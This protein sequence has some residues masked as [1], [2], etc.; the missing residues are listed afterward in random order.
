MSLTVDFWTFG[1]RENTTTIPSS[2]PVKTYSTVLL[3]DNCSV[4]NPALEIREAVTTRVMDW[5]Y[6]YIHEFRRYY[7]V[8]DWVWNLG[9]WVCELQVDVL[10]SFR[11]EIGNQNLYILRSYQ[12][13]SGNTL[14]DG[15]VVD[16]TYPCLASRATYTAYS[17]NNPFSGL[18]GNNDGTYIVGLINKSASGVKYYAFNFLGF[19]V[20]CSQLFN[21]SSG[22]LN[23]DP[24]EISEDLQKALVNPFQYLVSA[25]YIPIPVTW[26]T[27]NNIGTVTTTVEFGWWSV[28]VAQGG[29]ILDPGTLYQ[30]TTS[31]SIP[32]HPSYQSRGN[33]LNL[34][35]YSIYTLR[36]YPF[37]TFD[38]DSESISDWNTLDLYTDVDVCTGKALLT[39]AVNGK[40]NPIRTVESNISVPIPTASVNVDYMNLG[41]KSSLVMMGASAVGQLTSGEGTWFQNIAQ[42]GKNFISNVRTGNWGA[43]G[44]GAKQTASNILSSTMASKAT[45]EI[46]GQQGSYTLFD[47]QTLTLTGRF[48][49]VAPEDFE[50]RG[51]PLCQTR[52][53]NTLKGF[54]MCADADITVPCTDREKSAIQAYLEGGFYYY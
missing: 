47:T 34:S 7:W 28:T 20:L 26:F 25:F 39:L 22:W 21:Y 4:V 46:T 10:G 17:V 40:P 16:S 23:I 27:S 13:S 43:I 1:K 50:H 9:V 38:I 48:L 35:P 53:I 18:Y 49:P 51:R 52:R 30:F 15:N 33:Y 14:F 41:S 45:A 2:N 3:K 44:S 32:K 37:G 42:K 19:R 11:T 12:D 24:T 29:R 5:N 54:V 8:S 6:C 36:Y 31:L